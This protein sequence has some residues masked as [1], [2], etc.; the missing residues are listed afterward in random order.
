MIIIVMR[1][2]LTIQKVIRIKMKLT[3]TYLLMRVMVN[4][5]SCKS[6]ESTILYKRVVKILVI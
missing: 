5:N 3:E 2:T 6:I 4:Y 1:P